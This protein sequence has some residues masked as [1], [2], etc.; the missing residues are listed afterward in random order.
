VPHRCAAY[1]SIMHRVQ[2]PLTFHCITVETV[3]ASMRS[4][5]RAPL[6]LMLSWEACMHSRPGH[7]ERECVSSVRG[8]GTHTALVHTRHWYAQGNGAHGIGTHKAM[9]HTAMVHTRHWY[10]QGIGTHK[11]V[12]HTR[13]WYTRQWYTR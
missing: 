7:L 11:A 1:G 10:T 9:V 8:N 3:A 4:V 5:A 12:V 6:W 13:E 2:G